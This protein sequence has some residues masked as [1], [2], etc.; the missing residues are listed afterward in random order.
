MDRLDSKLLELAENALRDGG[1]TH[2]EPLEGDGS[3]PSL[4]ELIE[5][6][7]GYRWDARCEGDSF[8]GDE[9]R[10]GSAIQA[11]AWKNELGAD[12]RCG[13]CQPPRIRMVHWHDRQ[14][15]IHCAQVEKIGLNRHQRVQTVRAMRIQHAL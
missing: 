12:D 5:Q 2:D 3:S 13:K 11:R 10:K 15:D 8:G 14:N 9:I 6:C 7:H 1:A 4:T